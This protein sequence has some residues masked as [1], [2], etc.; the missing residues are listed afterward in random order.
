MFTFFSIN[1]GDS[2]EN[3]KVQDLYKFDELKL[4]RTSSFYTYQ[5]SC[6]L[7]KDILGTGSES[8][9]VRS[10]VNPFTNAET[11]VKRVMYADLESENDGE[12]KEVIKNSQAESICNKIFHKLGEFYESKE[13][14]YIL[15][16]KLPPSISQLYFEGTNQVTSYR[17]F[18]EI[19]IS[20][21]NVVKDLHTKG[22]S[23]GDLNAGNV[24]LDKKSMQAS[25]CDFNKIKMKNIRAFADDVYEIGSLISTFE[26]LKKLNLL[27]DK[28][29][30]KL[31]ELT[32]SMCNQEYELRISIDEVLTFLVKELKEIKEKQEVSHR[33]H[34]SYM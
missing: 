5:G 15:M 33:I 2:N 18:L 28:E 24:L 29:I 30:A 27:T 7:A 21:V 19:F 13:G 4:P 1:H 10:F 23:H 32:N 22:I 20:I 34:S 3:K 17:E 26:S 12:K 16:K 31:Q 9:D 14:V 6:S 25:L 8:S 11:A